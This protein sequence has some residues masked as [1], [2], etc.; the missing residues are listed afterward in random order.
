MV[1]QREAQVQPFGKLVGGLD[2]SVSGEGG[3][4]G[5]GPSL[6]AD[7]NDEGLR[8]GRVVDGNAE[9]AIVGRELGDRIFDAL[10]VIIDLLLPFGAESGKSYSWLRGRE[11][12][13]EKGRNHQEHGML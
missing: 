3:P 7:W 13:A 5:G 12:M 6:G 11:S 8:K 4:F 9:I 2:F 10:N 1:A